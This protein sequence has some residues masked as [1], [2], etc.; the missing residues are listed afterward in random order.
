MPL[1]D[2]VRVADEDALG[3]TL[4]VDLGSK[5]VAVCLCHRRKDRSLPLLGL[6]RWL[7]ARCIGILLGGLAAAGLVL[8][9]V[10]LS[11]LWAALLAA[12]LL[13]DW[14]S[15]FVGLRQSTNGLRL[16][17]GLLFGLSLAGAWSL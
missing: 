16:A 11:L 5:E 3:P 14:G 17:S 7:C 8:A 12:P 4:Y 15:Q 9:G 2:R 13:V 6:E 10:G 1:D